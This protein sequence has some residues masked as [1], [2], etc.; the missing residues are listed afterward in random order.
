MFTANKGAQLCQQREMGSGER[1]WGRF[2][3]IG[4]NKH[5]QG[6]DKRDISLLVAEEPR[7]Q[8]TPWKGWLLSSLERSVWSQKEKCDERR[9]AAE[10]T[11]RPPFHAPTL[12]C[13]DVR[14]GY[15]RASFFLCISFL[16]FFFSP[17]MGNENSTPCIEKGTVC[18][19]TLNGVL[20]FA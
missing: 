4:V 11:E 14:G 20:S 6:T 15:A 3:I 5:S 2:P 16:P 18:P 9:Q 19:S 13:L 8:R 10:R 17:S 1:R 12:S 7:V